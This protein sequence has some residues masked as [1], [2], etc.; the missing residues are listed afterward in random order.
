[1]DRY[2]KKPTKDSE[3]ER[4]KHDDGNDNGDDGARTIGRYGAKS[5]QWVFDEYP[6]NGWRRCDEVDAAG[7][8]GET[9]KW[10]VGPNVPTSPHSSPEACSPSTMATGTDSYQTGARFRPG[11]GG[12]LCL[13]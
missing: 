1:M 7:K 3:R 13:Q 12:I 8:L 11:R 4:G 5:L 6:A 2:E 10:E 9:I